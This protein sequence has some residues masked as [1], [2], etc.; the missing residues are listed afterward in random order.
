MIAVMIASAIESQY[1]GYNLKNREI[2]KFNT[3]RSPDFKLN[4]M[5]MPLNIKKATT[6]TCP[7]FKYLQ[8]PMK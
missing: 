8:N 6:P 1:A 2:Q 5:T 4:G 7:K 3:G